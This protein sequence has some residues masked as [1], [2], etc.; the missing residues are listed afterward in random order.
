M[1]KFR[2]KLPD[3][4]DYLSILDE[5]GNL[6]AEL[7]PHIP[8]DEVLRIHR[9]M[10]LGRRLDERMLN[11]QRQGRIG[12]FAPLRGQEA[13]QIGPVAVLREDDWLVPAFREHAAQ[14]MRGIPI[15]NLLLVYGGF[16]QGN[17]MEKDLHTLPVAVPVGTQPLHAV[18]LAYSIK[19][20]KEDRV[21]LVFFGEGATSEG[22]FHEAMNFAA[23]YQF[24]VIFVCQNNH[25][26][27]SIPRDSQT[28]SETIAQKALAYGMPG[29]QVDGNDFMAT[30]A[31]TKEAVERARAGGGPTLI[32]NVTYR[33]SVHTTSD[34]PKRYRPEAEVEQWE[35]CDPIPR[36]QRYL[37]EKGL[38]D[39]TKILAIEDEI[40]NEI[41][42]AVDRYEALTK[43]FAGDEISMFDHMY[44]QMPDYLQQQRDELAAELDAA[45]QGKGG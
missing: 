29:I 38:L 16:Y 6:D 27:I 43:T 36:I 32:E 24:P 1:P 14:V 22:D 3:H 42:A 26:A 18:G 25:Y 37:I 12:T 40:K 44:A 13:S 9:A 20:R 31:A 34:D 8:D 23:V 11:L 33:L 30:Y 17:Q 2:I 39:E 35:N 45:G 5:H 41:Q 4:I 10:L 28:G 21:A 7:D 15:E 19:Y